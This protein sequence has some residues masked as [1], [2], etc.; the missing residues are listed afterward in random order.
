M[1][2][3]RL[4]Q[5]LCSRICHDLITP[6]G[7]IN[8]GFELLGSNFENI[9]QEMSYLVQK[10]A[11]NAAQRLM[12]FR[13]GFSYG[14]QNLLSSFEKTEQLLRTFLTSHGI[15]FIWIDRNN[16]QTLV[17][18][19]DQPHWGRILVNLISIIIEVAPKGGELSLSFSDSNGHLSAHVS[20]KG[21]LVELKPAIGLALEGALAEQDVTAQSIQSYLTFILME[22]VSLQLKLVES[23]SQNIV[24]HLEN[25]TGSLQKS[26]TLF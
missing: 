22:A 17:N 8:N 5:L 14:G 4:A 1:E 23:N 13:A 11:Q 15:Q 21:N 7:A 19:N 10:S 3:L 26:G 25:Q 12:M 16:A 18:P 20:L 24:L 9:D 6:V 2:K